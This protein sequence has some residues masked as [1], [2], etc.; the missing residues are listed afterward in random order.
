MERITCVGK[1]KVRNVQNERL[2]AVNVAILA[3]SM[4]EGRR[5]YDAKMVNVVKM[6]KGAG[7][8]DG[9]L[10]HSEQF[11]KFAQNEVRKVWGA[12]AI[13]RRFENYFS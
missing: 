11:A 4:R 10:L 1:E 3:K 12:W 5:C 6:L 13:G 8:I 9:W 7:C 2:F